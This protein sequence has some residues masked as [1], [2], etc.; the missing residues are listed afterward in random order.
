MTASLE[1]VSAEV[2]SWPTTSLPSLHR[3]Y[4]EPDHKSSVFSGL[5]L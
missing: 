3:V 4:L 2:D 1:G 5:S